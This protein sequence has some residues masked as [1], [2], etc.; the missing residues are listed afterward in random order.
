MG[1]GKEMLCSN[2]ANALG[3]VAKQNSAMK[4]VIIA[5][6][7]EADYRGGALW[8]SLKE[9][10]LTPA[11]TIVL[12]PS[13]NGKVSGFPSTSDGMLVHQLQNQLRLS[14][15]TDT[16]PVSHSGMILNYD[17]EGKRCGANLW[18]ELVANPILTATSCKAR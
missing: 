15:D 7:P 6:T 17:A 10:G 5:V 14:N 4:H 1:D 8:A 2:M 9:K 11:N 3:A 13:S 18:R 12:F 16:S